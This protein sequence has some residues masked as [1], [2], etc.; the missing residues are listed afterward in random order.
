MPVNPRVITGGTLGQ[1]ARWGRPVTGAS[2]QI[3]SAVA[4]ADTAIGVLDTRPG[5]SSSSGQLD[6]TPPLDTRST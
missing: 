2:G 5:H 1:A 4:R 3:A 6:T